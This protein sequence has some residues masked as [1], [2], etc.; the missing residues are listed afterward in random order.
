MSRTTPARTPGHLG[1]ARFHAPTEDG[2]DAVFEREFGILS[3]HHVN[4]ITIPTLSDTLSVQLT[5]TIDSS[6]LH[7]VMGAAMDSV[8]GSNI[9]Q[10]NRLIVDDL[11]GRTLEL[12]LRLE[13]WRR[14]VS[15]PSFIHTGIDF[16]TWSAGDFEAQ[17]KTI[18]LSIFYY[19]TVLL[20]HG[21]LLMSVLETSTR[22]N[23]D[24]VSDVLRN[25]AECLLKDDL[26]VTNDFCH[27]IRGILAH[28]PSFFKRNAIWWTCNYAGLLA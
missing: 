15:S 10:T 28:R 24:A 13:R 21:T 7:E 3:Q 23:Q 4:N 18:L 25:T 19:R 26:M 20:V 22:K 14:Q 6:I 11:L 27:L 5:R 9:D 16:S 17:Q 12:S 2:R 1:H 8:C